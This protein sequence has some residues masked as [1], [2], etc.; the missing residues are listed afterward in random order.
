MLPTEM[1]SLALISAYGIGGS[2]VSRASSRWESGGQARER[3]AQRGVAL[4][5]QQFMVC[6]WSLLIADILVKHLPVGGLSA[7]NLLDPEAL[8]AGSWL[9]GTFGGD[10]KWWCV[11]ISHD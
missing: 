11:T 8:P 5:H 7:R 2:A 9:C 4:R 3:L 1:P 10:L 6:R